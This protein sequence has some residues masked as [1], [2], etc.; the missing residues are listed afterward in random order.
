M[1][2]TVLDDGDEEIYKQRVEESG[3]Y[4]TNVS[5]H[6]IDNLFKVPQS[7]WKKLYKYE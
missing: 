4:P 5:L 3:G 1:F 6:K 2:I 7:I